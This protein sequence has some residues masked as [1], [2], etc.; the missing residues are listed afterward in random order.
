M[1]ILQVNVVCGFGSTGRIV[2]D[3]YDILASKGHQCC[4]AYGRGSAPGKYQTYKIG[5][6]VDFFGHV[7]ETRFM[8]NHGFSSRRATKKFI[9][10]INQYQPDIIHLHN[11]H[12]YYLNVELLFNYLKST[13]I[14]IVWTMHDS[15]AV[16]GRSATIDFNKDGTIPFFTKNK[17]DMDK[18]PSTLLVNRSERNYLK[19]KKIFSGL[20]NLTIVTPSKWLKSLIKETFFEQYPIKVINNGIDITKFYPKDV[21]NLIQELQVKD[22]KIIL[23][24][25][26]IWLADKGIQFFYSLA[27]KVPDNYEIILVGKNDNHPEFKNIRFIDRTSSMEELADLYSLADVYVNPTL[28]DTF[29]TT[30]LESLA[31]GTP[32]LTFY[33][34]GSPEIIQYSNEGLV[35]QK[36]VDS[37]LKAIDCIV[38]KPNEYQIEF[39]DIKSRVDKNIRFL[40]YVSLY[41]K[42]INE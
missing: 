1:K 9:K 25:S 18:Y 28:I 22:K 3:L 30:N 38:S 24:V 35:V 29:P 17:V 15:W 6:S 37:L 36:D 2:T 5:N 16:S 20:D 14:R 33:S 4:I 41:E 27:S 34:G 13:S 23:G 8:D 31:C 12:G 39:S 40:E 26:S 11:I 7:F 21:S 10:F 19:K 32:I 42:S